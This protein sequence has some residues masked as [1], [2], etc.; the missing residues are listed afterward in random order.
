VTALLGAVLG[1]GVLANHNELVAMR[2]AGASPW[3]LARALAGM[4][5]ALIALAVLLQ[6]AIVPP[7]ERQAQSFRSK[8]LAQTALG[9]NEFWSRHERRFIRVGGVDYGRIPRGIEI[10]ELDR[11]GRLERLVAA[12]RADVI[13]ARE[14]LL[15][16]VEER[17]LDGTTVR[18]RALARLTWESFLTPEQLSTLIAPAHALSALDLHRYIEEMRGSGVDTRAYQSMMWRQLSL[19]VSLFAMT[20]LGLPLVLGSVRARSA[21]WRTLVGGGLGVGFYLFEQITG[22]LAQILELPPAPTALAPATVVLLAAL[23]GI[24]RFG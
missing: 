1:L 8:Q 6:G 10:Y 9:G 16:D 13:S 24:R 11:Q 7:V 12:D 14:W 18:H 19:P 15:H 20:L 17:L 22:H 21:G 3:R 4:A 2:A 23:A 5:T